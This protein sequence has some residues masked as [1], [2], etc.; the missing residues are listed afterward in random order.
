MENFNK[1]LFHPSFNNTIFEINRLN[2]QLPPKPSDQ[3]M[4]FQLYTY[5]PNGTLVT[6][7]EEIKSYKLDS[8]K[9]ETLSKTGTTI[10]AYDESINKFSGLE[11]TAFV[12]SHSLVIHHEKEFLPSNLLTF[13]FYTRAKTYTKK[14]KFI[15]FSHDPETDSKIDYVKDRTDFIINNTPGNSIVFIDGPLIGGQVSTYTIA[16]NEGLLKKNCIPIFFVKNSSSNLV[17]DNIQELKGNYNSD[18]HWAY[19]ILKKGERTNFF[20]YVDKHTGRNA[21]LFCYL[22]GFD[23]SPQR[24]EFHLNTYEKF[25]DQ[26]FGTVLNYDT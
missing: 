25:K 24:V 22:K 1:L 15:R 5:P 13:Y 12:T 8:K 10:C 4:D 14:S 16:L 9:G 19:R 20:R 3:E 7:V 18:M 17:T 21:K 6:N 2:I 26:I 23:V 11:G